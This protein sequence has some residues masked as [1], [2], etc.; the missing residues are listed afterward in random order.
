ML[1]WLALVVFLLLIAASAIFA[2]L[3]GLELWRAFKELGRRVTDELDGITRATREIELHLQAAATS[4]TALDA[5]VQRLGRSRAR[6]NVL[7]SALA[8]VR[9]SVG[10]VT[11]VMPRK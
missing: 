10:R 6:L 4:G 3:K 8:D 11:A 7:T 5:S 9:A 2:V 1:F